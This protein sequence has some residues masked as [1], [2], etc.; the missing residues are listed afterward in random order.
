MKHRLTV[1]IPTHNRPDTLPRA[2][3]SLYKQILP[4]NV[5]VADDGNSEN[6]DRTAAIIEELMPEAEHVLIDA[7]HAWQNWREGA[8]AAKS[9]FVSWLQDDDCVRPS[10]SKRI[11]DAFDR[12]PSANVWMARLLISVGDHM[13][14][15]WVGNGPWV[16]MDLIDGVP[17]CWA[18]GSILVSGSY[19]TSWAVAP[20]L[21]FRNQVL[22]HRA[23]DRMPEHCD[24]FVERM[25]PAYTSHGGPF[26]T[27]PVV[28]G[29]WVQHDNHLSTKLHPQQPKQTK[30]ILPELDRMLDVMPNWEESF[31]SWAEIVPTQNVLQWIGNVEQTIREGGHTKYGQRIQ[32]ALV[33]SLDGRVQF[34]SKPRRWWRG[35]MGWITNGGDWMIHKLD[36]M[37]GREPRPCLEPLVTTNLKTFTPPGGV[38]ECN[39]IT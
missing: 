22:F 20:A 25:I 26:I 11:V 8:R 14:Y 3:D 24:L 21:A 12:Y 10:Y 13:A 2:L 30:I 5:I 4:V 27:D 16:P 15:W 32:K 31:L 9:E 23:L 35:T 17:T 37:I 19:L 38:P 33:K 39:R 1:V 28:A 6:N 29:Y 7:D 18:E 34:F 36:G